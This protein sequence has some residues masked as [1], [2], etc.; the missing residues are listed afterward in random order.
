MARQQE[1]VEIGFNEVRELT[2]GAAS[3]ITFQVL[4]GTV[5][6][7]RAAALPSAAD[8]GWQYLT[9]QGERDIALSSIS[10]ASGDRVFGIGKAHPVTEVLVDHA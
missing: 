3:S 9:G 10:T 1:V 5:E 7:I 6:I 4:E 2:D 8:R